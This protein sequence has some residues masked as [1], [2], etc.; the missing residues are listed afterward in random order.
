MA[1]LD[2]AGLLNGVVEVDGNQNQNQGSTH[3]WQQVTNVKKRKLQESRDRKKAAAAATAN[4]TA[5]ALA[6]TALGKSLPDPSQK[7][8]EKLD[9]LPGRPLARPNGVD[10]DTLLIRCLKSDSD[11]TDDET[12]A[13]GP[14]SNGQDGEAVKPAKVKKPKKPKVT[15][16][17]AAAAI[18]PDDLSAFLNEASSSFVDDPSIPL[19]R[20]GDYFVKAFNSV[21]PSSLMWQK[22]TLVKASEMPFSQLPE[23]LVK[24]TYD[25][26]CHQPADELSK[27]V[28]ML[29]RAIVEDS[30][31]P[32]PAKG[33]KGASGPPGTG[34]LRVGIIVILSLLLRK[35][36]DVLLQH[37]DM[38]RT[39]P[40][41]K[42]QDEA[43][44]LAWVYTQVAH[45]DLVS[46]VFLWARNLV[47][48]AGNKSATPLSRDLALQFFEGMVVGNLKKAKPMLMN[49]ASKKGERLIPAASL[50]LIMRLAYP[51]ETAQT[52][53]TER[54]LAIYPVVKEAA[55]AGASR[56][57]TLKAAAAQLFPLSLSVVGEDNE[58]LV[59]EGCKNAVWCLSQNPDCYRQWEKIHVENLIEGKKVLSYI[60][61][62]WEHCKSELAPL[63]DFQYGLKSL[64][65][66][67]ADAIRQCKSDGALVGH[68]RA[69]DKVCRSL[70]RKFAKWWP[71]ALATVVALAGASAVAVVSMSPELLE[72]ME[73]MA[74]FP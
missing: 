2:D 42:G 72:K 27:F 58:T 46:G 17:D 18:N 28:M 40:L 73:M 56:S 43:R 5:A 4:G 67:N 24:V 8:F 61:R 41:F 9:A 1:E 50:D 45:G 35:R 19:M 37:A 53:A 32:Q 71:C 63:K 52:K 57:K 44:I 47:T 33:Q 21:T 30:H 29:L 23:Q 51:S 3:G 20:C 64:R 11:E 48:L 7:A 55:L 60:L 31:P 16:A 62:N 36:P 65:K 12:P 59:E 69:V 49:G 70:E 15:V 14:S 74:K 38:L 34:K 66:K 68:L 25:W 6:R 10:Y 26:L 22:S 39:D 54:F 13:A